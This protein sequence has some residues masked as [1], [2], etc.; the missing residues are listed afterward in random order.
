MV[1]FLFYLILF[2]YHTN[3]FEPFSSPLCTFNEDCRDVKTCVQRNGSETIPLKIC[4][5]EPGTEVMTQI[6]SFFRLEIRIF[7]QRM[8]DSLPDTTEKSITIESHRN[9]ELI[10]Q[11]KCGNSNA[12]RIVGGEIV[13]VGSMPWM[14]LLHYEPTDRT[15]FKRFMCGGSLISP[16]YVLTAAH[17]LEIQFYKL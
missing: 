11:P 4:R 2:R 15:H 16:R 9:I 1:V 7:F 5:L 12:N 6:L 17:C 14:A 13:T 10:N 3:I 8:K